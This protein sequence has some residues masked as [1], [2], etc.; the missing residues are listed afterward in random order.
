MPWSVGVGCSAS[1][2]NDFTIFTIF[3]IFNFTDW[4]ETRVTKIEAV[5]ACVTAKDQCFS[6]AGCFPVS[7]H[8]TSSF[9]AHSLL[10]GAS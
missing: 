6:V 1:T 2:N 5:S 10:R 9:S 7:H 4:T 8:P 3:N